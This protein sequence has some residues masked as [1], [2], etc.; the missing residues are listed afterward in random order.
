MQPFGPPVDVYAEA[1]V[2]R[3]GALVAD[4][5]FVALTHAGGVRSHLWVS[6]TAA[7]LGPRFRV[8]GPRMWCTGWT[9]C[10]RAG[11]PPSPAGASA[12]G[13]LGVPGD[14]RPVPAYQDFYAGVVR[15]LR[16][17]AAPPVTLQEAV[18]GLG[19]IE[20]ALRW[21]SLRSLPDRP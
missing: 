16:D 21:I 1:A 7:D 19:I 2:R 9:R 3:P 10:E 8:T 20:T 18:T 14:V 6:A 13:S 5:A 12:Y 4:D 17:G 15:C 11:R